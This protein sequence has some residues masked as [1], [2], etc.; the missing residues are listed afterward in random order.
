MAAK[1]VETFLE[2]HTLQKRHFIPLPN[3]LVPKLLLLLL[4]LQIHSQST[5]VCSERNPYIFQTLITRYV[6]IKTLISIF[7]LQL[8]LPTLMYMILR[9]YL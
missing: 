6:L 3:G 1:T 5:I 2:C 7:N 4:L 8:I 9:T